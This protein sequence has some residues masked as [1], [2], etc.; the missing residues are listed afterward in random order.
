MIDMRLSPSYLPQLSAPFDIIVNKLDDESID[1]TLSNTDPNEL[2]PTQ[3]ITFSDHVANVD[4]EDDNP[5]WVAKDNKIID[6]HHRWNKALDNNES[7]MVIVVDLNF[8]DACRVLNKIQD[9]YEYDEQRKLEEISTIQNSVNDANRTDSGFEDDFLTS[10]GDNNELVEYEESNKN[11]IKIIAY[12]KEPIKE[13]SV[14]G[15]F[16]MIQPIDGYQKYEIEFDNLL[17][18]DDVGLSYKDS[19]NPIDVISKI[20]FPNVNFTR[21]SDEYNTT[22]EN[23]KAKAV[24]ENAIKLGYDG[25]KYGDKIIQGLK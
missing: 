11:N 22:P 6:G 20:W 24:A 9:I 15:N 7:I 12:R 5:I 4:I 13:N 25:I 3:G 23:L 1:Y 21:L 16:F 14:V 18:T 8:K 17:D 2:I 10:L 19:Q